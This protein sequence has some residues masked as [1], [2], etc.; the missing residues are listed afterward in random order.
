M[1]INVDAGVTVSGAGVTAS[2]ITSPGV[3][4]PLR[5]GYACGVGVPLPTVTIT[6]VDNVVAGIRES[7]FSVAPTDTVNTRTGP[8]PASSPARRVQRDLLL[9]EYSRSLRATTARAAYV[10]TAGTAAVNGSY[11]LVRLR[12]AVAVPE[13]AVAAAEGNASAIAAVAAVVADVSRLLPASA[14]S[15]GA[16]DLAYGTFL[17]AVASSVGVNVSALSVGSTGAPTVAA[18]AGSTS[19]SPSTGSASSGLAAG[20]VAGI[21]I[22]LLLA[23]CLAVACFC[24]IVRRRKAAPKEASAV[25]SAGAVPTQTNPLHASNEKAEPSLRVV[26]PAGTPAPLLSTAPTANPCDG[27]AAKPTDSIPVVR[28]PMLVQRDLRSASSVATASEQAP[29]GASAATGSAGGTAAAPVLPQPPRKPQSSRHP[30]AP[31]TDSGKAASPASAAA[32]PAPLT[33]SRRPLDSS[34]DAY[35]NPLSRALVESVALQRRAGVDVRGAA[36]APVSAAPHD[37]VDSSGAEPLAAAPVAAAGPP[38]PQ[39]PRLRREALL[40]PTPPP[41]SAAVSQL[42]APSSADASAGAA[43]AAHGDDSMTAHAPQLPRSR[44]ARVSRAG[45]R[46]ARGASAGANAPVP[47]ADAGTE[48]GPPSSSATPAAVSAGGPGDVAPPSAAV[49]SLAGPAPPSDVTGSP[50]G[51]VS[52]AASV[53][54][55]VVLSSVAASTASAAQ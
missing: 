19:S 1:Y 12:I 26:P 42:A 33:S 49:G 31:A 25:P 37:A 15:S 14:N 21:V 34:L 4:F 47:Q 54:G 28:N 3:L 23:I 45:A 8:C 52:S 35:T 50:V 51:L 10:A 6:G 36:P 30:E 22:A 32:A 2:A 44:T 27:E 43:G 18:A 11:I 41:R 17:V 5:L 7:S 13:G 20:A 55:P 48:A 53:S 39:L 40:L 9:L 38:T 24:F 16:F 29:A 46:A